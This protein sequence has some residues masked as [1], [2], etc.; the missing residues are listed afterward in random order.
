MGKHLIAGFVGATAMFAVMT[1]MGAA[2]QDSKPDLGKKL[3]Q[4]RAVM[5]MSHHKE[6]REFLKPTEKNPDLAKALV[7]FYSAIDDLG[8]DEDGA[9]LI[10]V[11]T[12][13]TLAQAKKEAGK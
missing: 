2:P 3:D 11:L 6:I 8:K 9:T 1:V 10:Y 12:G 4:L 5:V 13:K 7:P